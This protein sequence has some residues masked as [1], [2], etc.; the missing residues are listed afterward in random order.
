LTNDATIVAA[1]W[2]LGIDQLATN[3]TDF[4]RVDGLRVYAPAP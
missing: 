4:D 3:D 2:E 1:A